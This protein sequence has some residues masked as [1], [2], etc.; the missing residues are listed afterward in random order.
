MELK[1]SPNIKLKIESIRCFY[2]APWFPSPDISTS[3]VHIEASTF[4]ALW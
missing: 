4:T 1:Y 2:V 3:L